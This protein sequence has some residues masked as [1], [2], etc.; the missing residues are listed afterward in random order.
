MVTGVIGRVIIGILVLVEELYDRRPTN[1]EDV[2]HRASLSWVFSSHLVTH[3]LLPENAP[4]GLLK[5]VY[6]LKTLKKE[7]S[8]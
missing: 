7:C 5:D 8:P 3:M 4:F 6:G 1:L 2:V